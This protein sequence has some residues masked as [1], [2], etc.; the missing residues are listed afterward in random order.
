MLPTGLYLR[1]LYHPTWYD[2]RW[3]KIK[4]TRGGREHRLPLSLIIYI[5]IAPIGMGPIPDKTVS[6]R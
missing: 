6:G 5:G 4:V 3:G 2:D 1:Y